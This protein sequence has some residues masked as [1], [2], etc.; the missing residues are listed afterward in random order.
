MTIMEEML[1]AVFSV[2]SIMPK[3]YN[4]EQMRLQQNIVTA[5]KRAGGWCETATSLIVSYEAAA[6]Q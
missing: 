6:G 2:L 5:V 3:L 4:K 1:E